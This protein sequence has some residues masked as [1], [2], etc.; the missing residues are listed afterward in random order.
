MVGQ[1]AEPSGRSRARPSPNRRPAAAPRGGGVASS[2]LHFCLNAL[3]EFTS[4]QLVDMVQRSPGNALRYINFLVQQIDALPAGALAE[5]GGDPTFAA[6]SLGDSTFASL[7][8]TLERV[9]HEVNAS[10]TSSSDGDVREE[11][12]RVALVALIGMAVRQEKLSKI[13]DVVAL[14]LGSPSGTIRPALVRPSLDKIAHKDEESFLLSPCKIP[15]G[16]GALFSLKMQPHKNSSGPADE[17]GH[18]QASR[19]PRGA[20]VLLPARRNAPPQ[21]QQGAADGEQGDLLPGGLMQLPPKV[22]RVATGIPKRVEQVTITAPGVLYLGT[23]FTVHFEHSVS[24]I[25][26]EADWI[27]LYRCSEAPAGAGRD[28]LPRA[29]SPLPSGSM[30]PVARRRGLT[31]EIDTDRSAASG[32]GGD[33]ALE[34]SIVG[35]RFYLATAERRK[36]GLVWE[37]ECGPPSSGTYEFRYFHGPGTQSLVARSAPVLAVQRFCSLASSGSVLFL[38][39]EIGFQ[40]LSL[41]MDLP[42]CNGAKASGG[43]KYSAMS[44]LAYCDNRLFVRSPGINGSVA[45]LDQNSF[46]V[47]RVVSVVGGGVPEEPAP[48]RASAMNP[49][50]VVSRESRNVRSPMC[51][52]G[53]YLYVVNFEETDKHGRN[54]FQFDSG[55]T[56]EKEASEQKSSNDGAEESK[57]DLEYLDDEGPTPLAAESSNKF[58]IVV[59]VVDPSRSTYPLVKQVTLT[60]GRV[61]GHSRCKDIWRKAKVAADPFASLLGAVDG[62]IE[63]GGADGAGGGKPSLH[64]A[65]YVGMG[66]ESVCEE[67]GCVSSWTLNCSASGI[68]QVAVW[69]RISRSQ[70]KLVGSNKFRVQNGYQTV[71]IPPSSRIN[72]QAGDHIGAIDASPIFS[73][74]GGA[75]RVYQK[76]VSSPDLSPSQNGLVRFNPKPQNATFALV[77]HLGKCRDGASG[78]GEKE[79]LGNDRE[80]YDDGPLPENDAFLSKL[81]VRDIGP[82]NFSMYC[83]GNYISFLLSHADNSIYKFNEEVANF[84]SDSRAATTRCRTFSLLDGAIRNDFLQD[85]DRTH[86]AT[87][88]DAKNGCLWSANIQNHS[89]DKF[90][91]SSVSPSWLLCK[92]LP[93]PAT[94]DTLASGQ[95]PLQ[96]MAALLLSKLSSVCASVSP[97]DPHVM[98]HNEAMKNAFCFEQEEIILASSTSTKAGLGPCLKQGM[99]VSARYGPGWFAG[100]ISRV[101]D[102]GTYVILYA[103]G[104]IRTAVPADNIKVLLPDGSEIISTKWRPLSNPKSYFSETFLETQWALPKDDTFVPFI[105]EANVQ[106]FSSLYNVISSSFLAY[107]GAVNKS[108]GG[109]GASGLQSHTPEAYGQILVDLLQILDANVQ[110]LLT[111]NIDISVFHTTSVTR[112]G[113]GGTE[114]DTLLLDAFKDILQTMVSDK[115]TCHVLK[116][117]EAANKSLTLGLDLWF[118]DTD[119]QLELLNAILQ[120]TERLVSRKTST[121][122]SLL[123]VQF[124]RQATICKIVSSAVHLTER[125]TLRPSHNESTRGLFRDTLESLVEI[126]TKRTL[127]RLDNVLQNVEFDAA[128]KPEEE[129]ILDLL[130]AFHLECLSVVAENPFELHDDFRKQVILTFAAMENILE[131]AVDYKSKRDAAENAKGDDHLERVFVILETSIVGKLVPLHTTILSSLLC[132]G[133]G[134]GSDV[135]HYRKNLHGSIDLRH[136]QWIEKLLECTLSSLRKM[137]TFTSLSK[138]QRNEQRFK[139]TEKSA[140]AS[141]DALYKNLVFFC[142]VLGGSLVRISPPMDR[143]L[144]CTPSNSRTMK[145]E[146]QNFRVYTLSQWWLASPL[147]GGGMALEDVNKEKSAATVEILQENERVF[148]DTVIQ[149]SGNLG[150]PTHRLAVAAISPARKKMH[151]NLGPG[152]SPI[153]RSL[154]DGSASSH[155][156]EIAR[157]KSNITRRNLAVG[158]A[159]VNEAERAVAAALIHHCGLVEA[160]KAY[161]KTFETASS[162]SE[163]SE[164]DDLNAHDKDPKLPSPPEILVK[165]WK[166]ARRARKWLKEQKDRRQ[167]NASMYE[168]LAKIVIERSTF[169]LDVQP[170][171]KSSTGWH[172]DSICSEIL[173]FVTAPAEDIDISIIETTLKAYPKMI[174][175]R[176]VG[177]KAICKFA[178][179]TKDPLILLEFLVPIS[180][181]ITQIPHIMCSGLAKKPLNE[182]YKKTLGVLGNV[183]QSLCSLMLTKG[184]AL[185]ENSSMTILTLFYIVSELYKQVDISAILGSNIFAALSK[186]LSTFN[187]LKS[188][189][190]SNSYPVPSLVQKSIP[191]I[192]ENMAEVELLPYV[193][194]SSINGVHSRDPSVLLKPEGY[195]QSEG[196]LPH[197]LQLTVPHGVLIKDFSILFIDENDEKSPAQIGNRIDHSYCPRVLS[198]YVGKSKRHL[199]QIRS[200]DIGISH[201]WVK[202]FGARELA[203]HPDCVNGEIS[204]IRLEIAHNHMSGQNSRIA[205]VKLKAATP[206]GSADFRNFL[207]P[208]MA[209]FASFAKRTTID[210]IIKEFDYVQVGSDAEWNALNCIKDGLNK[211]LSI[212]ELFA[213]TFL[214][215]ILPMIPC[216][217]FT[218]IVKYLSSASLLLKTIEQV[219][220]GQGILSLGSARLLRKGLSSKSPAFWEDILHQGN[221]T[222]GGIV[223]ILMKKLALALDKKYVSTQHDSYRFD[224]AISET[225]SIFR[226]LCKES[227]WASEIA[228]VFIKM[229]NNSNE[230]LQGDRSS[231]FERVSNSLRLS[232]SILL[233]LG[234]HT[235]KI[236]VGGYVRQRNIETEGSTSD[237]SFRKSQKRGNQKLLVVEVLQS[238]SALPMYCE[239]QVAKCVTTTSGIVRVK[240][241]KKKSQLLHE[242]DFKLP[243][244][245]P[246]AADNVLPVPEKDIPEALSSLW[247]RVELQAFLKTI[248]CDTQPFQFTEEGSCLW[249]ETKTFALKTMTDMI[250]V[251]NVSKFVSSDKNVVSKIMSIL[252]H[253]ILGVAKTCEQ[254]EGIEKMEQQATLLKELCVQKTRTHAA[255]VRSIVEVKR[256]QAVLPAKKRDFDGTTE[257]E[258]KVDVNEI[259]LSEVE[260]SKDDKSRVG[261]GEDNTASP[262]AWRMQVTCGGINVEVDANLVHCSEQLRA[263]FNDDRVGGELLTLADLYSVSTSDYGSRTVLFVRESELG[264]LRHLHELSNMAVCVVVLDSLPKISAKELT[265]FTSESI[266]CLPALCISIS[267][268][269]GSLILKPP[270]LETVKD[271]ESWRDGIAVGDDID[272]LFSPTGTWARATVINMGHRYVPSKRFLRITYHG[273]PSRFDKW[274]CRWSASVAPYQSKSASICHTRLQILGDQSIEKWRLELKK[275]SVIDAKDTMGNWYKSI[276]IDTKGDDIKLHYQGWKPRW[277]IWLSKFSNDISCLCSMTRPWRNFRVGDIVDSNPRTRDDHTAWTE[278]KIVK[279]DID[280]T[281]G[282]ILRACIEFTQMIGEPRKW[283]KVDSEELCVPG[284]HVTTKRKEKYKKPTL[285]RSVKKLLVPKT[286]NDIQTLLSLGYGEALCNTAMDQSGNDISSALHWLFQRTARAS[287]ALPK[288]TPAIDEAAGLPGVK[289]ISGKPGTHCTL[290]NKTKSSTQTLAFWFKVTGDTVT[291]SGSITT[292][293]TM[294]D[295]VALV[296]SGNKIQKPFTNDMQVR[297]LHFSK[298][299]VGTITKINRDSTFSIALKEDGKVISVPRTNIRQ[300]GSSCNSFQATLDRKRRVCISASTVDAQSGGCILH[301][302]RSSSAIAG[303]VWT[304]IALV[305]LEDSLNGSGSVTTYIDGIADGEVTFSGILLQKSNELNLC[306]STDERG[307]PSMVK[308]VNVIPKALTAFHIIA[309]MRLC[310]VAHANKPHSVFGKV[311]IKPETITNVLTES[312]EAHDHANDTKV[313]DKLEEVSKY[314]TDD[315]KV[316]VEDTDT[317][318]RNQSPSFDTDDYATKQ[319]EQTEEILDSQANLEISV[320]LPARM[321]VA[322]RIAEQQAQ[323]V[324]VNTLSNRGKLTTYNS[325]PPTI[326]S[327]EGTPTQLHLLR[328]GAAVQGRVGSRWY[329]G[330]IHAI[331]LDGSIDVCFD[332]NDFRPSVPSDRIRIL[333]EDG[334]WVLAFDV[335]K[336][337]LPEMQE[338]FVLKRKSLNKL[339]QLRLSMN[340]ALQTV[341]AEHVMLHIMSSGCLVEADKDDKDNKEGGGG[342]DEKSTI[343]STVL[344]NSHGQNLFVRFLRI[345]AERPMSVLRKMKRMSNFRVNVEKAALVDSIL[346]SPCG[347]VQ[348]T[349]TA[350]DLIRPRVLSSL[351]KEKVNFKSDTA[352]SS[353]FF[354][355]LVSECIGCLLLF[356]QTKYEERKENP[357]GDEKYTFWLLDVLVTFLERQRLSRKQATDKKPSAWSRHVDAC[358]FNAKFCPLVVKAANSANESEIVTVVMLLTRYLRLAAS[359]TSPLQN[360]GE[361][362]IDTSIFSTLGKAFAQRYQK[363]QLTMSKS[364][365]GGVPIFSIYCQALAQLL[366][367][368]KKLGM[369]LPGG[370]EASI[371]S[372]FAAGSTVRSLNRRMQ[373]VGIDLGESLSMCQELFEVESVMDELERGSRADTDQDIDSE[374]TRLVNLAAEKKRVSSLRVRMDDAVNTWKD[375]TEGG[376]KSYKYPKLSSLLLDDEK[377][378]NVLVAMQLRL[379]LIRKFNKLLSSTL[380]LIDLRHLNAP[381]YRDASETV[382]GD[383]LGERVCRHRNII[384]LDVKRGFLSRLMKCSVATAGEERYNP[385]CLLSLK[386]N[387]WVGTTSSRPKLSQTVFGQLF[388]QLGSVDSV[389]FRTKQ[390]PW[391]VTFEGEAG[392]DAG[393]PF[394]S[395]LMFF[396]DDLMSG[397]LPLFIPTPNQRGG[398]GSDRHNFTLNPEARAEWGRYYEFIGKILGVGLRHETNCPINMTSLFWKFLVGSAPDLE[399]IS[400][401][402]Q[403]TASFIACMRE[404]GKTELRA[405]CDGLKWTMHNSD[406]GVTVLHQNEDSPVGVSDIPDYVDRVVKFRLNESAIAA[407]WLLRGLRHVVPVDTFRLFSWN[408]LELEMCGKSTLDVELLKR[409]TVFEFGDT[410]FQGWFWSVLDTLTPMQQAGCLRFWAARDRLPLTDEGMGECKFRI[411][412]M[413]RRGDMD[414]CLPEA[415]TCSFTLT[416]PRYS[417]PVVMKNRLI[418]AIENC[419]EYDLDGAARGVVLSEDT[420]I[421]SAS[422]DD[423]DND[424]DDSS[425]G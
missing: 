26:D 142:G 211:E 74:D 62:S 157:Q 228:R 186:C 12:L 293:S 394:R 163:G 417:S 14:L 162:S 128:A 119:Q 227:A 244:I 113:R 47:K 253:P 349:E 54:Y 39:N 53:R 173:K 112:R 301:Q 170:Y 409:N 85:S 380:P 239:D 193:E 281:S 396:C 73:I 123:L 407:S 366:L 175:S 400:N 332:D 48:G 252:A 348:T 213:P 268:L 29:S 245:V 326:L 339:R 51:S 169:L 115:A 389:S 190:L 127:L 134:D 144:P 200:L 312:S 361:P 299:V 6:A 55:D 415:A 46:E 42:V 275:G 372:K 205:Q 207:L 217:S 250:S 124:A 177:L 313:P 77:A 402:D 10:S 390:R 397:K 143:K 19:P 234:G 106:A 176:I 152:L 341:Y 230:I 219:W 267:G 140:S 158:I 308:D 43:A 294:E 421:E 148:L 379:E 257:E 68:V 121:S 165:L 58:R 258:T 307:P 296:L 64:C 72:V 279:V 5:L 160:T 221:A 180:K 212:S 35:D 189:E 254:T 65:S 408:E 8:R 93:A 264:E 155:I 410:V 75:G 33:V 378:R 187:K 236:R 204:I 311:P 297:V 278:G 130:V 90:A 125:N 404:M 352:S 387:R 259:L 342:N 83:N 184:D 328:K 220:E 290:V 13:L 413:R 141:V 37:A 333:L 367:E 370:V 198:V 96:R 255:S 382:V 340:L 331:N 159:I 61:V 276:I 226:D 343:F 260:D 104:D 15:N 103:D 27:G 420:S 105:L 89:I 246:L 233:V 317:T 150:A 411:V 406:G 192:I 384:F 21:Q 172:F 87:C 324:D 109:A 56:F 266:E 41:G 300:E 283:F 314:D 94:S 358:F 206:G 137:K 101:N 356:S 31:V 330:K 337:S 273:L 310:S 265:A 286:S 164:D 3:T 237:D 131:K 171:C 229:L 285:P 395:S 178:E 215:T 295:H 401:L 287:D 249:Q 40:R 183:T 345:A 120:D 298:W 52:D 98:N 247:G 22:V 329:P 28:G 4:M 243:N 319:D 63:A 416:L 368:V 271:C 191:S 182:Q 365:A 133:S 11:I 305:I 338:K 135:T 223:D 70:F 44:W 18:E 225:I 102:D 218:V 168:E 30:G 57:E 136:Q 188:A 248:M 181:A 323:V 116:L 423:N 288:E 16:S 386:L 335:S 9:V 374:L 350:L 391:Q 167:G 100:E 412:E 302:A 274:V 146:Q 122:Y 269:S 235:E 208:Q 232:A 195:W 197:W 369:V 321:S 373:W 353:S 304:H 107:C 79:P 66:M 20:P 419:S 238:E 403:G 322:T 398:V 108:M 385:D 49:A 327:R 194:V 346:Q 17:S 261:P 209:L 91:A 147:F 201:N 185:Q 282:I 45:E 67:P 34:S 359:M 388:Q 364:Q 242:D 263:E 1:R 153:A 117:Q 280:K 99:S 362:K 393:G 240:A 95:V 224:T 179:D 59:N 202:I 149:A 84:P 277:D 418:I 76:I 399:D 174:A 210:H 69:R 284:T 351:E 97:V 139:E 132:P 291:T 303:G 405:V 334:N 336:H 272:V 156:Q 424:D 375:A 216:K 256:S 306:G 347:N 2:P 289:C 315:D 110:L 161:A 78:E 325:A 354:L 82:H 138:E 381:V 80:G 81:L 166:N 270:F 92:K 262:H 376:L 129:P 86:L 371:S 251:P 316:S 292:S 154:S 88:Y 377:C 203:E 7:Q 214:S 145:R 196:N 363:E 355:S 50:P 71:H 360:N 199:Q 344:G 60:L 23:S 357:N 318:N 320:T 231:N 392:E 309:L 36:N 425:S 222:G 422:E 414:K 24:Y 383:G 241:S 151:P 118:R 32:D 114:E 126:N 25:S 111:K 38:Q